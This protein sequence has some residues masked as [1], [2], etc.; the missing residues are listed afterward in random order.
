MKKTL[1]AS[2]LLTSAA[3]PA[4]YAAD[5]QINF[6]GE[7]I[8]AACTVDPADA[9]Q[10][11]PLGKMASTAFS[12]SGTTAGVAPFKISL[13]AC[14]NS[15]SDV[16]VRFDGS[17][18]A[19]NPQLLEVNGGAGGL[20]IALYEEDGSTLI[21]INSNSKVKSIASGSAIQLNFIA[22]YMAT[23]NTVT[24]GNANASAQFTV[25]YQ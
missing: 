20:G 3:M 5:G 17:A 23:A 13:T 25:D 24:A 10:T 8:A 19:D 9:T 14:D 12:A 22:K 2:L 21:P 15:I 6:T 1:I 11:V 7:I 4:A 18:D 16:S